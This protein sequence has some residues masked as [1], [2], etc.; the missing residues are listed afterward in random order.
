MLN[1]IVSLGQSPA[2]QIENL[3]ATLNDAASMLLNTNIASSNLS[4]D[5]KVAAQEMQ[6]LFNEMIQLAQLSPEELK[7]KRSS[8]LLSSSKLSKAS[9]N[10]VRV[11]EA[12]RFLNLLNQF[13]DTAAKTLNVVP[14]GVTQTEQTLSVISQ[15]VVELNKIQSELKKSGQKLLN[16]KNMSSKLKTAL[17]NLVSMQQLG[18]KKK[19]GNINYLKKLINQYQ[20]YVAGALAA[21]NVFGDNVEK[22]TKSLS[23]LIGTQVENGV[24]I[25]TTHAFGSLP[26]AKVQHM[27]SDTGEE[28]PQNGEPITWKMSGKHKGLNGGEVSALLDFASYMSNGVSN[29]KIDLTLTTTDPDTDESIQYNSSIKGT[30]TGSKELN[31][32]NGMPL[33]ALLINALDDPE[34]AF[35]ALATRLTYERDKR[36]PARKNSRVVGPI[37]TA[38]SNELLISFLTTALVGSKYERY[39]AGG[40]SGT[41]LVNT[42]ITF[43]PKRMPNP[44]K[45]YSTKDLLDK[46]T[47]SQ[48]VASY[49]K[50]SPAGALSQASNILDIRQAWVRYKKSKNTA[51]INDL[52]AS[53]RT[54]AQIAKLHQIK[55]S[56]AMNISKI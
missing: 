54:A 30:L 5:D 49:M 28:L 34:L 19:I 56:I 29:A 42:L 33:T 15:M 41:Q 44:Y 43:D 40:F 21:Q 2:T 12:S 46:V 26:T 37:F 32:L 17:S 4:A 24:N 7:A 23:D 6:D 45:I 39:D 14:T 18:G 38:N 13:I 25:L 55:L 47:K 31:L 36:I 10:E 20:I 35:N 50:I 9:S 11:N 16:D 27:R 53:V 1:S 8:S 52:A 22:L 51:P 48:T 3:E